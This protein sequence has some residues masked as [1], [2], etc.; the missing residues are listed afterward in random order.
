MGKDRDPGWMPCSPPLSTVSVLQGCFPTGSSS[1]QICP[2]LFGFTASLQ[3][4]QPDIQVD[5][6]PDKQRSSG[7]RSD[8]DSGGQRSS[9]QRSG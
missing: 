8:R 7:Q 1:T 4:M 3:D 2:Y 9:G 6:S 5:S